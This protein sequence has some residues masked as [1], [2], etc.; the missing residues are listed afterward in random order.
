MAYATVD[1][2][3]L[4]HSMDGA[5]PGQVATLLDDAAIIL[6]SLVRVDESD[7]DQMQKLAYVSCNM[8]ARALTAMKSDA[9]GVDEMR[10]EMG[11]FAQ[12]VHYQNPN[13]DLYITK[14][15]KRVLGIHGRGR[16]LYPHYGTHHGPRHWHHP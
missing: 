2:Y 14:N 7:T 4:H 3:A 5:D 1:E 9:F 8:V 13:G 15:E 10:A 16:I 6:D 12:T 11:P